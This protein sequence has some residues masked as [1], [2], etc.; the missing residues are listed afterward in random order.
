MDIEDELPDRLCSQNLYFLDDE[1]AQKIS[2]LIKKAR[3]AATKQKAR[4][5][6]DWADS[7]AWRPHMH[8][9]GK[10]VE[11]LE[12]IGIK[13]DRRE[14]KRIAVPPIKNK[15]MS[16]EDVL[17]LSWLGFNCFCLGYAVVRLYLLI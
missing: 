10:V 16:L 7:L 8:H 3:A 5:Y 17:V 11:F 4:R 1:E 6:L 15:K 14:Y 12:S 13:Q 9:L 2:D